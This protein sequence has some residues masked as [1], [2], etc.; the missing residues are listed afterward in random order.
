M[1]SKLPGVQIRNVN[2]RQEMHQ[3][4]LCRK[5]LTLR[6][7]VV[8]STSVRRARV[9]NWKSVCVVFLRCRVQC[10]EIYAE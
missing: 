5:D 7:F 4:G 6:H 8:S 10:V 1:L 3:S 9:I 2:F